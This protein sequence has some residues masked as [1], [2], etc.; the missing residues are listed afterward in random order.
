[1]SRRSFEIYEEETRREVLRAVSKSLGAPSSRRGNSA[2]AARWV[3]A[4][5]GDLGNRAWRAT[6]RGVADGGRAADRGPA[7]R[8][9]GPESVEKL[10][11]SIVSA[12]S[13]EQKSGENGPQTTSPSRDA[14]HGL[15][16]NPINDLSSNELKIL[17]KMVRRLSQEGDVLPG[18]VA[19]SFTIQ[20][21]SVDDGR[22]LVVCS[23]EQGSG[24]GFAKNNEITS[25]IVLFLVTCLVSF[26][27]T[28][29]FKYLS[30]W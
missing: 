18:A 12:V 25:M 21:Q 23:H 15:E 10:V 19:A 26:E 11:R 3:R 6:P 14:K 30:T 16:T 24:S 20:D 9:V 5:T 1:M 7:P 22:D 28:L 29:L 27:T 4:S 2:T 13:G 8:A 17:A